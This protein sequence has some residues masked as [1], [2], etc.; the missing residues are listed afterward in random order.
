MTKIIVMTDIHITKKRNKIIGLDP[1][2]RFQNAY[3]SALRD[4]PDA[5]LIILMGDLTH[6]GRPIQ[7]QRLRDAL[8]NCPIPV[9]PMLGNHDIREAFREVFTDAPADEAGFV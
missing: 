8:H 7:Y 6:H 2:E 5:S 9:P 4:H 3:T 1:M